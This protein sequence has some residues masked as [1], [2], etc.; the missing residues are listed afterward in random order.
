MRWWL[1]RWWLIWRIP[2]RGL[3]QHRDRVL[4]VL[5]TVLDR[6]VVADAAPWRRRVAHEP[7][8]EA[9]APPPASDRRHTPL[10]DSRE[11]AVPCD[12]C[13]KPTWNIDPVCDRCDR[14]TER[15]MGVG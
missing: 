12:F 2:E 11:R 8:Q 9:A 3:R 14:R 7:A 15:A 5:D 6:V 10:G 4:R 13:S 1:I